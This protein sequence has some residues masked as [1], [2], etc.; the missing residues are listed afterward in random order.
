MSVAFT[1][2]NHKYVSIDGDDISWTSTTSFIAK[3]KQPF[4][5]DRVAE[6]VSKSKKSK[7]Y[8]K[9][10]DEI[11]AIWNGEA[12]RAMELGNWYHDQ[13]EADLLEFKTIERYGKEV[14][15]VRPLLEGQRKLAPSQKLSE[16]VY[17]EHLVY[18]KSAGISG[19][20]DLVEVVDGYVHITDYKT[21]KEIK[22]KSYVNWEG[23]SQKMFDPVAHLD[24]CNLKHYNLQLSL[25]MY[26][27]LKHN[28]RLKPGNL[29]I[30]HV[31]FKK[32]GEDANGY[33]IYVRDDRGDF[34]IEDIVYYELPYLKEEVVKMLNWHKEN[35]S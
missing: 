18:L 34:I 6:R 35:K 2:H 17:P 21:N 13:R 5:K 1:D 4:D 14:P 12:E 19:Q 26:I 3:F 25:Y 20:S 9:T 16:G 29:V 32:E 24:D 8:G 28:R 33:P 11:K 30:Q 7:W 23:V 31:K 15:I 22:S 27:I 10:P